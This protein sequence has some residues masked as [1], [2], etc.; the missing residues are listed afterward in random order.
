MVLAKG[1]WEKA[2]FGKIDPQVIPKV[3]KEINAHCPNRRWRQRDAATVILKMLAFYPAGFCKLRCF[4]ECLDLQMK[5]LPASDASV[6]KAKGQNELSPAEN[7]QNYKR[8]ISVMLR[9]RRT[10]RHRS[11]AW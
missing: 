5:N 3:V 8:A 4:G 1:G 9:A 6:N 2:R 11:P 7:T 10:T